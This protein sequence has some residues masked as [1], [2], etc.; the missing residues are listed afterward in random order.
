MKLVKD[1][2]QSNGLESKVDFRGA[3]CFGTCHLGPVIEI[4]GKIYE[5]LNEQSLIQLLDKKLNTPK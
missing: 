4:D 1:Y 3:H 2:I 5:K